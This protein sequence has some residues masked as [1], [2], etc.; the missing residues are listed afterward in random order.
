V[1]LDPAGLLS[2]TSGGI[3]LIDDLEAVSKQNLSLLSN[4]L[5]PVSPLYVSR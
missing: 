2:L 3:L 1:I 5:W 4:G